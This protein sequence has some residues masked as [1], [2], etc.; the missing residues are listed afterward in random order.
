VI[1]ENDFSTVFMLFIG[2]L[3]I[4]AINVMTVQVDIVIL[5]I[6]MD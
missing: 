2:L 1:T 6:F 4:V 5:I 3:T